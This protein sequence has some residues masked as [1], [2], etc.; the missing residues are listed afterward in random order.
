MLPPGSAKDE[1]RADNVS[2]LAG[3]VAFLLERDPDL[4]PRR[5]GAL[6]PVERI[7]GRLGAEIRAE[8]EHQTVQSS[9]EGLEELLDERGA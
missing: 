8:S 5:F 1:V 4:Q 9:T 2:V 6:R 3:G 7:Q